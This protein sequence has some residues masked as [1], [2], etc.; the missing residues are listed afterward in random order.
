MPISVFNE[1]N[2]IALSVE[3]ILGFKIIEICL[4]TKTV[5]FTIFSSFIRNVGGSLPLP[6]GSIFLISFIKF[7]FTAEDEISASDLVEYH[8]KYLEDKK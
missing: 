5:V 4:L 7:V 3:P 8:E 2:E 6:N 1:L